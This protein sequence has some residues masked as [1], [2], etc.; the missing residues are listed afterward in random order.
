ME[1]IEL[2]CRQHLDVE[3]VHVLCTGMNLRKLI[4]DD[5][6]Q[7]ELVLGCWEMV[8][9]RIPTKYELY[10]FE[11][12]QHITDVWITIRG[13]S[14]AKEFTT[15]FATRNKKGTRRTLKQGSTTE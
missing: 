5:V 10:S 2:V 12:L 8:A 14:F 1:S 11:L 15:K 3:S 6:L 4:S 13:H 9:H 7:S